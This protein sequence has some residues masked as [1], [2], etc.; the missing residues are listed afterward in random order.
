MRMLAPLRDIDHFPDALAVASA[1]PASRL[2]A[3]V[4]SVMGAAA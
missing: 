4:G 1:M 3:A 2:A